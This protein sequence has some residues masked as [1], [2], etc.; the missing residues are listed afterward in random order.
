VDEEEGKPQAFDK[1]GNPMMLDEN[2][3]EA[4]VVKMR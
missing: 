3:C 4:S 1:E 2:P